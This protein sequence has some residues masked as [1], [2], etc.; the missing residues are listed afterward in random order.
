M[1]ENNPNTTEDPTRTNQ[2]DKKQ[3][4]RTSTPTTRALT[5]AIRRMLGRLFYVGDDK[6]PEQ[7]TIESIKNSVDFQGA[8]LWILILAIFVAS[9][10][11]NT[12]SAAVIIGAML[13]SPIM[14]PI[15]GMGLGVGINDFELFKR[16]FRSFCTATAFSVLTATFYFLVTPIAEAQ[17]ELLAR[18]APTI[19]DVFIALCGG[20]AGIIA[21]SSISQRSGN[22]IPGVAIATALMPPICT[23]GFGIATGNWL[24]AAGAFYLYMINSI[25]I[26]LAT[27]LGVHIM[28]FQK[29]VFVDKQREKRVKHIIAT[30]AVVTMIPASW[31]TYRLARETMF[32]KKAADFVHK[33]LE[34][35]SCQIVTRDFSFYENSIRIV[36]FGQEL[37]QKDIDRITAKL[38][39][40][41]LKDTKLTVVQGGNNLKAEELKQILSSNTAAAVA[42]EQVRRIAE[43]Q[44]QIDSLKKE[45]I[46]YQQY[47]EAVRSLR[48]EMHTLFPQVDEITLG[49][50]IRFAANDS[51]PEQTAVIVLVGT[52]ADGTGNKKR[53]TTSGKLSEEERK[54]LTEWLRQRIG[55]ETL[56]VI[57]EETK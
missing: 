21:L 39:N 25:F 7:E 6:A 16:S 56:R 14:G 43:Q 53:R 51:T 31:L 42:S 12:N 26:S 44:R 18:T 38:S 32:E 13:I 11:L 48:K 1:T 41:G 52:R 10:G 55:A 4:D 8:K 23:T 15:M 33:E 24:Y 47:T 2:G 57:F 9:L 50:G 45:L 54:R 22:V 30:I 35:D 36:V 19:Y 49:R 17:S 29:K 3:K 20:L 46:P 5:A 34:S 40:Y 37:A 27:F 28:H